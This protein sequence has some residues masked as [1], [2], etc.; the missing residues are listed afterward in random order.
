MRLKVV[1]L[2]MP[3]WQ[4]QAQLW[5]QLHH[6]QPA[7]SVQVQCDSSGLQDSQMH[8]YAQIVPVVLALKNEEC[9][10]CWWLGVRQLELWCLQ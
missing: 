3:G 9:R 10:H 8:G 7:M 4:V 6:P 2:Q 5:L 1:Q